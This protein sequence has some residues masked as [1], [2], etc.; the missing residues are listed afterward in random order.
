[1]NTIEPTE[2][3]ALL[4]EGYCCVDP[5]VGEHL[6]RGYVAGTITDD[7]R[8]EFEQH[9]VFCRKCQ[10]DLRYLTW[11]ISQTKEYQHA[12]FS[13]S[14]TEGALMVTAV[15]DGLRHNLLDEYR[16]MPFTDRLAAAAD[17]TVEL[18]FPYQVEYQHGQVI[19]EFRKRAGQLF[20][21]ATQHQNGPELASL[22]LVYTSP[23]D[24]TDIKRFE[25]RVNE[26]T[27]LGAF[28]EFVPQE[29]VQGMVAALR[30]FQ[31]WVIP[32]ER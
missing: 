1:M 17:E 16:E 5:E 20:F 26:D 21:K 10:E 7:Q 30:Q 4:A 15:F 19:G 32:N 23:C 22:M 9:F 25:L 31:V 28:A 2:E 13:P 11:V 6:L 27:S 3:M 18:E 12:I 24:S 14:F 29:T 8:Q